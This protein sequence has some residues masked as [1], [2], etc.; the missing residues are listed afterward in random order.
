MKKNTRALLL[1]SKPQS[2]FEINVKSPTF[3]IRVAELTKHEQCPRPGDCGSTGGGGGWVILIF[4]IK[5]V[6][7]SEK[8]HFDLFFRIFRQNV[9][10]A[11]V[12][13]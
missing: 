6:A 10:F 13:R 1:F 2:T 11:K 8:Y 3:P 9:R 4:L 7:I 12:Y 5:T